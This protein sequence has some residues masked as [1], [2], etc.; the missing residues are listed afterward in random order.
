MLGCLALALL[1]NGCGS[2]GSSS[3][4]FRSRA[5]AICRELG[6]QNGSA[7]NTKASLDR[8]LREADAGI[9]RLT[10]LQPPRGDEHSYRDLIATLR[11]TMSL[12]RTRFPALIETKQPNGQMVERLVRP[13]ARDIKRADTDARAVDLGACAKAISGGSGTSSGSSNGPTPQQVKSPAKSAYDRQMLTVNEHYTNARNRVAAPYAKAFR[14]GQR[15]L[16]KAVRAMTRKEVGIDNDEA[17]AIAR[18]KAPADAR[19][20]Q[21]A[22]AAAYRVAAKQA[23]E[24]AVSYR[25]HGHTSLPAFARI[26]WQAQIQTA[27][28]RLEAKGYAL[29][30]FGA[31]GTLTVSSSSTIVKSTQP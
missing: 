9:D 10:R 8:H 24:V 31:I 4:A 18:I 26:D 21:Q 22:I 25:H 27:V 17:S 28:H 13:L 2:S 7:V 12:A 11:R 23:A 5:D 20:E 6:L 16:G 30:G 29:G 1:A 14:H 19:A 15:A 3:V